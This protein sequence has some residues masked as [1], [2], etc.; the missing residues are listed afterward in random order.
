M[1]DTNDVILV[2]G[3]YWNTSAKIWETMELDPVDL[4]T[5]SIKTMNLNIRA[6]NCLSRSRIMSMGELI[7]YSP[8]DLMKLR[9]LG[10]LSLHIILNECDRVLS[11]YIEKRL[12]SDTLRFGGYSNAILAK[13]NGIVTNVISSMKTSVDEVKQESV[14]EQLLLCLSDD[15]L[16]E[17]SSTDYSQAIDL[18]AQSKSDFYF[19]RRTVSEE[20]KALRLSTVVHAYYITTGETPYL[21]VVGSDETIGSINA[22][23]FLNYYDGEY[24]RRLYRWI[25]APFTKVEKD[26]YHNSLSDK[27]KH[28]IRRKVRGQSNETIGLEMGVTGQR[29]QQI[30]ARGVKTILYWLRVTGF[31]GYLYAFTGKEVISVDDACK[32]FN[33]EVAKAVWYSLKK[34]KETELSG[35][36]YN[37][38]KKNNSIRVASPL[39]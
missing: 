36:R 33:S 9:N 39:Q 23:K 22:K 35:S 25:C 27:E 3:K 34:A 5:M 11:E 32:V 4:Y 18:L 8:N 17:K 1:E 26:V 29:I 30:G 21:N 24:W 28:V 2:N 19:W 10:Q 31:I 38:I 37:Y 15:S 16:W 6:Y 7:N 12:E 14:L 20:V 13:L